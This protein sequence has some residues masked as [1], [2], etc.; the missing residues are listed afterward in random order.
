[1][2]R[3]PARA[4]VYARKVAI[5]LYAPGGTIPEKPTR[6]KPR[7]LEG[8][9]HRSILAWMRVALPKD[10]CSEP[11]HTPNGGQR[12]AIAGKK[13]KD[14]GTLAGMPDLAFLYKKGD[15]T[16]LFFIEVKAPDEPLSGPQ[17]KTVCMLEQYGAY[18]AVARSV[19]EARDIVRRWGIAT[20]EVTP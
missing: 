14:M 19:D 7:D 15:I 9:I 1:M 17:V 4:T 13:L 5:A 2:N 3:P 8:P 16:R 12:N 18:V 20:R 6:K 10:A 11:W